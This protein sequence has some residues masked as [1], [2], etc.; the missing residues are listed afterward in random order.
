MAESSL[1]SPGIEPGPTVWK[2]G[3]RAGP[4]PRA[5]CDGHC[6]FESW[7]IAEDEPELEPPLQ[8]TKP[9]QREN[10]N[11]CKV[12]QIL[13]TMGLHWQYGSNS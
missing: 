11:R 9:H 3:E 4:S 12:R 1:P 5:I 2:L 6:N 13:Y 10:Y 7:S 8:T